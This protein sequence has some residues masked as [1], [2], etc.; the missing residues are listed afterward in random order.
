MP[1]GPKEVEVAQQGGNTGGVNE[2]IFHGR[3]F[4]SHQGVEWRRVPMTGHSS[5]FLLQRALGDHQDTFYCHC[6]RVLKRKLQH[7]EDQLS[8]SGLVAK[9]PRGSQ[10]GGV[11][12]NFTVKLYLPHHCQTLSWLSG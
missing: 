2:A 9:V 7:R 4:G 5:C 10:S 11:P 6:G 1:R 3:G 12:A 8:I